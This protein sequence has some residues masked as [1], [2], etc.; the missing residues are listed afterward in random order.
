MDKNVV[1]KLHS[2]FED[3]FRKN[4]ETGI[5]YWLARDL[6]MLLGYA[7]WENFLKVIEK[8]VEAN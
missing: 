5:E 2:S 6:Q 4:P 3:M 8:F 7:R 1:V